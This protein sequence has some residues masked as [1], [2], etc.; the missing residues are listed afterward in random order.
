MDLFIH[1]DSQIP[2]KKG[3]I[4]LPFECTICLSQFTLKDS[5]LR[6]MRQI[7]KGEEGI[8]ERKKAILE[9]KPFS[10]EKCNKKFAHIR[11]L[12]NHK[13]KNNCGTKQCKFCDKTFEKQKRLTVHERTHT[14]LFSCKYCGKR[15]SLA[16]QKRIHEK[17][18]SHKNLSNIEESTCKICGSEFGNNTQLQ[19]HLSDVHS[20]MKN[21][22]DF[23]KDDHK[24]MI[25]MSLDAVIKKEPRDIGEN[26]PE[27]SM[28]EINLDTD[29]SIKIELEETNEHSDAEIMA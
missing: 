2:N 21:E 6:H 3:L 4:Q 24:I 1:K 15:L 12:K 22:E 7:H 20:K 29:L 9:E 19:F 25:E 18:C 17:S 11:N 16:T 5:L 10:C 27:K 8:V 14:K 26:S 23:E 13:A 28:V